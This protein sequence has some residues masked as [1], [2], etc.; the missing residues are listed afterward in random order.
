MNRV[1]V[2]VAFGVAGLIGSGAGCEEKK[3]APV[4]PA[5]VTAPAAPVKAAE[6]PPA[7]KP[8]ITDAVK[9]A[10]ADAAKQAEEAVRQAAAALKDKSIAGLQNQLD[11]V[12]TQLDGLMKKAGEVSMPTKVALD[13]VVKE[14]N[15]QYEAAQTKVSGLVTSMD[16]DKALA[17]AKGS[18]ESL[19]K[20][21]AGAVTQFG[22]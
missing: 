16:W 22:K 14:L 8:G 17:D 3:P 21:A 12:R 9:T 1:A 5:K 18:V 13:A 15:T 20:A 6:V 11:T 19:A 7:P 10:G 4:T 2:V